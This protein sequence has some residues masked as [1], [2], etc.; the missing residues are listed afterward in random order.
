M[1]VLTCRDI[2]GVRDAEISG[3]TSREFQ[4]HV[5]DYIYGTV[6]GEHKSAA[7]KFDGGHDDPKSRPST[8]R[9]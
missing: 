1:K 7:R 9:N 3:D 4:K 6:D 5:R 8:S 2:G